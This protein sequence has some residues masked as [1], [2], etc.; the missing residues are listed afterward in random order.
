LLDIC[1][2]SAYMSHMALSSRLSTIAA[3]AGAIVLIGLAMLAG[4][5][6]TAE[7]TTRT[8]AGVVMLVEGE[9]TK[10]DRD[11]REGLAARPIPAGD[12]QRLRCSAIGAEAFVLPGQPIVMYDEDGVVL[13]QGLL[14]QP[15]PAPVVDLRT[16]RT[17]MSCRL[18]FTINAVERKGNVAIEIG[19]RERRTYTSRELDASNWNVELRVDR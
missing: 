14:G 12:A 5:L 17:S 2:K 13:G 6:V 16:G 15:V 8:L 1:S 19:S 3:V 7:P 9:V 4:A 18:P 10:F 11:V